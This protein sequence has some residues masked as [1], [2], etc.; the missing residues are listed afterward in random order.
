MGMPLGLVS[1]TVSWRHIPGNSNHLLIQST[2][3][4]AIEPRLSIGIP[5]IGCPDYFTLI[6]DRAKAFNVPLDNPKFFPDSLWKI[7][8]SSDAAATEYRVGDESKNPF[9]G[10]KILV[11]SGA[12]DKLVPWD[13][14]R[15][16]VEN[17]NVGE[18]GVKRVMVQ[19]G[20]GHEC[21]PEMIGEM[22]HFLHEQLKFSN[23]L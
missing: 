22:S 4:S 16:F 17:L 20:A 18:T 11:M 10:K 13:A 23:K 12:A 5:I 3:I 7:I 14:S 15:E 2:S 1:R 21:T 9:V 8:N 6:S 19:E